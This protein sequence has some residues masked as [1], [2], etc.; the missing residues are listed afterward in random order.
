MHHTAEQ[1]PIPEACASPAS[2]THAVVP[3][4]LLGRAGV[5]E[6]PVDKGFDVV[7]VELL[8]VGGCEKAILV[9]SRT[10][11]CVLHTFAQFS[12]SLITGHEA[13]TK[14]TD[15]LQGN[16]GALPDQKRLLPAVVACV[17]SARAKSDS[18]Y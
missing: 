7:H 1:W 13:V 15:N 16:Q 4:K 6:L 3:R 8:A 17:H 10:P 2:N 5:R 12:L 18:Y 14:H 9:A 11:G